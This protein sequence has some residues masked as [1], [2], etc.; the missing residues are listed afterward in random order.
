MR[1]IPAI[2]SILRLHSPRKNI[3]QGT[4]KCYDKIVAAAQ[5]S[6]PLLMSSALRKCG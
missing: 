3:S 1:A 6:H 2:F 5:R 4:N